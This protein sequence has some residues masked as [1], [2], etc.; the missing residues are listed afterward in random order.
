MYK[1]FTLIETFCLSL[2]R[3]TDPRGSWIVSVDFNVCKLEKDCQKSVQIFE[4]AHHQL[5]SVRWPLHHTEPGFL[6]N[7]TSM[8]ISCWIDSYFF[9]S[10]T[11]WGFS[12]LCWNYFVEVSDSQEFSSSVLFSCNSSFSLS[13]SVRKCTTFVSSLMRY[14]GPNNRTWI[15]N[16]ESPPASIIKNVLWEPFGSCLFCLS[17]SLSSSP[18]VYFQLLQS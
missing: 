1:H 13:T 18:L 11:N 9:E 8:K 6:L 12:N 16:F 7:G 10:S 17:D 14:L 2:S 3:G 5:C 4:N 15:T